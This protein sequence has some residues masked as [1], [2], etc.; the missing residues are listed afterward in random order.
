MHQVL[1]IS[2]RI[3]LDYSRKNL[4]HLSCVLKPVKDRSNSIKIAD[5]WVSQNRISF[6]FFQADFGLHFDRPSFEL[7]HQLR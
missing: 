3:F 2:R 4:V 6:E 1:M 7:D 5:R